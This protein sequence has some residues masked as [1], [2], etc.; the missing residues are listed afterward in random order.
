MPSVLIV[1]G[2]DDMRWANMLSLQLQAADYRVTTALSLAKARAYLACAKPDV[3]LLNVALPDGDGIDFCTKQQGITDAHILFCT[4]RH[5]DD[6]EQRALA[7]G[8]DCYLS[9]SICMELITARIEAA[10][11]QRKRMRRSGTEA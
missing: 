1:D 7:S 8:G 11:R 5:T 10:I 3:I 6:E 2:E 4:S 9:K